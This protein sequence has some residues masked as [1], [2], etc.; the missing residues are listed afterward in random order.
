MAWLWGLVTLVVAEA[1]RG[2]TCAG[3]GPGASYG[4][5]CSPRAALSLAGGLVVPAHADRAAPPPESGG[6]TQALLVGLP[7]PD[8]TTTTT[9]W[10]GAVAGS[11]PA[12]EASRAATPDAVRVEPGDTLWGLAAATLAGRRRP[13]TR[14]TAAGVRSTAR[15]ATPSAPTPT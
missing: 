10:L 6:T 3:R 1:L 4:G 2:R 5:R 9:E 12:R 7:V 14:S 8:R 11:R 13:P 15:T